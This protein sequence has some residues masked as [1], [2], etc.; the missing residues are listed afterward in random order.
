MKKALL[1]QTLESIGGLLL[2]GLVQ[3]LAG[4]SPDW[5]CVQHWQERNCLFSFRTSPKSVHSP[6][7]PCYYLHSTP[8]LIPTCY[9][10]TSDSSLTAFL[11]SWWTHH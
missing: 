9:F 8:S 5:G 7:V 10:L 1:V 6:L 3:G 2:S 4:L 11:G